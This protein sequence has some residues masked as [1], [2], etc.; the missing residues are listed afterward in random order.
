MAGRLRKAVRAFG[1]CLQLSRRMRDRAATAAAESSLGTALAEVGDYEGAVDHHHKHLLFCKE[2]GDRRGQMHALASLAETHCRAAEHVRRDSDPST[3]PGRASS[4]LSSAAGTR[5]PHAHA[6][7]AHF[8]TSA[9]SAGGGGM[10]E[11]LVCG[12][13]VG[14]TA[15]PLR[16]DAA[17]GRAL[18]P[19]EEA[20]LRAREEAEQEARAQSLV[21]GS[22]MER[23][24][25]EG[26]AA[27]MHEREVAT[28]AVDPGAAEL[29]AD[30]GGDFG[31]GGRGRG[32]AARLQLQDHLGAAG[33]SEQ[34][35][36][37]VA[38]AASKRGT[39]PLSLNTA[40]ALEPEA[41]SAVEVLVARAMEAGGQQE[42]VDEASAA[43]RAQEAQD[44][45]GRSL[46]LA[47]V[48]G[49]AVG[50]A[51]ALEGLG[52]ACALLEQWRAAEQWLTE[53]LG[54]LD[55]V[56]DLVA[57]TRTHEKRGHALMHLSEFRR[58]ADAYQQQ[59]ACAKRLGDDKA[60]ARAYA[61]LG[62]AY[63]AWFH[64]LRGRAD[65]SSRMREAESASKDGS[66]RDLLERVR[67]MQG[68]SARGANQP[69][70]AASPAEGFRP[71]AVE[72]TVRWQSYG[73]SGA[74][75]QSVESAAATSRHLSSAS[76][77]RPGTV[78]LLD[79]LPKP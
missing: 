75:A 14:D 44:L 8:Q 32:S 71:G 62:G 27:L 72:R 26:E 21:L 29:P 13:G 39:H 61:H 36:S 70:T 76:S 59:H 6:A 68:D 17:T 49:D 5:R 65:A 12:D 31:G 55:R 51:R 79:L 69:P 38:E 7:P 45:L 74:E 10:A 25:E 60:Q 22:A 50:D 58:S 24:H 78:E 18:R 64:S 56:G 15:A 33:V 40:P 1:T 16:V 66:E 2:V 4:A 41:Q 73:R 23:A 54:V 67:E 63:R 43:E 35:A 53:A 19:E 42:P 52:T 46:E 9:G 77:A 30:K 48:L 37:R 20:A 34:A 28:G 57:T 3:A 11:V 47:R